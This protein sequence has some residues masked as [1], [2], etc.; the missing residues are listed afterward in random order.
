MLSFPIA[1]TPGEPIHKQI[2]FAVKKALARGLLKPGDK[3]PAVRA[4]SMELKINP[5]TVQ[6]AVTEL[7]SQKVLE[8]FPGKGSYIAQKPETD[9]KKLNETMEKIIEKLIIEAK[10][11]GLTKNELASYVSEQWNL[12]LKR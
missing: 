3:F 9:T 5:N 4:I 2:I 11:A 10:Q 7:A 6:K 12:F 1:L 8:S